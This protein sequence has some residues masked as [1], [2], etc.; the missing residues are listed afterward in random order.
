MIQKDK[1]GIDDF[2]K[3]LTTKSLRLSGMLVVLQIEQSSRLHHSSLPDAA[4]VFFQ[5]LRDVE[6]IEKS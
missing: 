2:V 4:K 1:V 6:T 5:K 3:E